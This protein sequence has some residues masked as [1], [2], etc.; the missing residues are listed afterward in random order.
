MTK[1][2]MVV[3][4]ASMLILAVLVCFNGNNSRK[5]GENSVFAQQVPAKAHGERW[6]Y[7][8]VAL[9]PVHNITEKRD[10]LNK[11]GLDGW[12]LVSVAPVVGRDVDIHVCYFKR[13]LP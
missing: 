3:V 10:T 2:F 13:R 6:E 1:K 11:L 4:V 12:E 8:L 7:Y 5:S 9:P